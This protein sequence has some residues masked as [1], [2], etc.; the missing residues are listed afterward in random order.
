V[1]CGSVDIKRLPLEQLAA[2]SMQHLRDYKTLE[3][4]SKSSLYRERW[5]VASVIPEAVETYKDLAKIP[6]ITG[7]EL[8]SAINEGPMEEVLC[9]NAVLHWL[10]TTGTTGA[11]KWIPYG[12]RDVE[13]FMEIRDR[14]YSLLPIPEGVKGFAVSAPPPFAENALAG[15]NMIQGMLTHTQVGGVTCSVTEVEQEDEINF[16]FSMRP[17][18]FAGFPSFAARLAEMIEEEAPVVAQRE[19]GKKKSLRNLAALLLTRVKKIQPRDLSRFK[20]GLFGGEP[21]EPYREVLERVYGFEAYEMYSFTEFLPPVV[22]CHVHDGMHVWID[23]CLPEIIPLPELDKESVDNTYS[24]RAIPLW[25]AEHGMRGEYVLTTFGEA[26]PLV[27]YRVADLIE[28]VSTSPCR[29]GITHPR[30]KVLRRSDDTICLGAI[31]FPASQ[32]DEKLLAETRFGRAR[33]WQLKISREGYR[34]KLIIRVEPCGK[35]ADEG[36][37]L[38]EISS[39]LHELEILALGVE[40]GLVAK[41]VIVLEERITDEGRRVTKTGRVIYEGEKC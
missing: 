13:L 36:S 2:I 29:C 37:F 6:F 35:I 28:V 12:E 21:L 1:N 25:K 3:R 5:R 19:F 22:E 41:P 30:I 14:D 20:W 23:L 10:T 27:R 33:R 9:S 18:V 40:N 26:L 4:A 34:P 24:P 16:A 32:L 11:S 7:R 39:R 8:R 38:K 31:R 17:K 15:F